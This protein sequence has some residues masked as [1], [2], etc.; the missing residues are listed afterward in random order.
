M[1]SDGSFLPV[2]CVS[3]NLCFFL[4]EQ[5]QFQYK[6]L[7]TTRILLVPCP[8]ATESVEPIKNEVIEILKIRQKTRKSQN[9]DAKW[10]QESTVAPT[11]ILYDIHAKKTHLDMTMRR[12]GCC[13]TCNMP[14][15]VV[16]CVE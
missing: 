13:D 14:I 15:I 5:S 3:L 10:W 11:I 12:K 4:E 9:K 8:S 7:Y 6:P 16:S 1:F 2:I